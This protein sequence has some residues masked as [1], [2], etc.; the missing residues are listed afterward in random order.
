MEIKTTYNFDKLISVLPSNIKLTRNRPN[1]GGG[2]PEF[3]KRHRLDERGNRLDEKG[4]RYPSYG[5]KIE[6]I[7]LGVVKQMF[8]KNGGYVP[9]KSNIVYPELFNELKI[10][11]K[12]IDPDFKWD[13]I[14]VNHNFKAIKHKDGKNVGQGIIVSVGDYTGGQLKIYDKEDILYKS[15][16]IKNKPIK[17]NGSLL[18]HET[19]DFIGDRWSFVWYRKQKSSNKST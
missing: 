13:S 4:K 10:A 19:E 6:S 14:S 1:V 5:K 16:D 2:D 17:F 12:T 7:S 9:S 3:I 15:F 18:S 8:K 11:I